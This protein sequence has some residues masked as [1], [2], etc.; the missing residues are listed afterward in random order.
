[1]AQEQYS[2]AAKVLQLLGIVANIV[3]YSAI[4][5]WPVAVFAGVITVPAGIAACF[6]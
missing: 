2:R 1:M 4:G 6:D 3:L 5:L